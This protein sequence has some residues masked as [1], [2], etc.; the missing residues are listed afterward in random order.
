MSAEPGNTQQNRVRVQ[1]VRGFNRHKPS[2]QRRW[3]W[4]R[5]SYCYCCCCLLLEKVCCRCHISVAVVA[6]A[7][8]S[9]LCS[10]KHMSG[11]DFSSSNFVPNFKFGTRKHKTESSTCTTGSRVRLTSRAYSDAEP[12]LVCPTAAAV[13]LLEKLC[14][15]RYRTQSLL[16]G[17]DGTCHLLFLLDE[18]CQVQIFRLQILKTWPIFKLLEIAFSRLAKNLPNEMA[19]GTNLP[20]KGLGNIHKKAWQKTCEN[21]WQI[22]ISQDKW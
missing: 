5:V 16:N 4:P 8:K 1:R 14:C 17:S 20:T 13:L 6:P 3:P 10:R 22:Q 12:G 19:N 2:V 21:N 15:C 11:A 9:A 7:T 18:T